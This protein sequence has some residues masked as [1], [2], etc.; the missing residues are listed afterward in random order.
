MRRLRASGHKALV[1]L[2]CLTGG[3]S[4]DILHRLVALRRPA[5][6][7]GGDA[8]R[9]AAQIRDRGYYVFD[10][11]IPGDV[12][13]RLLA[14][15]LAESGYERG[16]PARVRYDLD[17][18]RILQSGDAQALMADPELLAVAE[19]YLGSRPLLDFVAMWWHTSF[20]TQPDKDAGQWFHFDMDR[21]KWLKFFIYLTD[22]GPEN[23]PHTFVAGSHR[24]GGIP[25]SI[26]KKGQVRIDDAEVQRAYAEGDAVELCGP[27][28]TIIAEDT[29]GLH[30]GR[31]VRSGDRLVFQLQYSDIIFGADYPRP[32]GFAVTDALRDAARRHPGVFSRFV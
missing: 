8:A 7:A 9:I 26:L 23:G 32:S 31:A 13:E 5:R 21:I 24:S 27:R 15:S 17:E 30:K 3:W 19:A 1:S 14:F 25:R 12:C 10:R 20:S 2:F 4:N 11:R 28:G 16:R 6:E 29:R 18:S 22:V